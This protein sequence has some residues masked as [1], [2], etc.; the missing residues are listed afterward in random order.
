VSATARLELR[1]PDVRRFVDEADTLAALFSVARRDAMPWLC[2]VH[3]DEETREWMRGQVLPKQSVWVAALRHEIVGFAA[4]DG[5]WLMHLYVKSGWTRHGIGQ[6]LLDAVIAEAK[7]KTPVLRV[8][9]FQRN[10]GARRF[11]ERNGFA[12]ARLGDGQGNEE[13]EPDVVYEL[14]LKR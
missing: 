9:T 4:R 10:T 7:S 12:A 3:S 1:R 11:Y 13:G 5:A 14:A 6:Q 8:A 2:V